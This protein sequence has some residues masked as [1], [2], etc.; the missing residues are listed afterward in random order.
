MLMNRSQAFLYI[1]TPRLDHKLIS[2]TLPDKPNSPK[3]KY[4][5]HKPSSVEWIGKMPKHG[6]K[7]LRSNSDE[8]PF[9]IQKAIEE[10]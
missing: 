1:Q 8:S 9:K 4:R 7:H 5:K 3:Q 10:I 2:L 6:E